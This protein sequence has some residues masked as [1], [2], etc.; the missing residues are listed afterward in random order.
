MLITTERAIRH[1]TGARA[2][3]LPLS[4]L[5]EPVSRERKC[6]IAASSASL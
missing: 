5:S 2:S 1:I 4:Q 6:L 3:A